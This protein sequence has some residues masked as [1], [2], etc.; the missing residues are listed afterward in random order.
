M[1]ITKSTSLSFTV[2]I[3]FSLIIHAFV[4]AGVRV[5]NPAPS[6]SL[7]YISVTSIET[8]TPRRQIL[9]KMKDLPWKDLKESDTNKEKVSA[10]PIEA[11]HH[12]LQTE[13]PKT[14]IAG[15]SNF[16]HDQNYVISE[17]KQGILQQNQI[18]GPEMGKI[19]AV[20]E[21]IPVPGT[22]ENS[23]V[24]KPVTERLKFDLYWLGMYVGSATL[25]AVYDNGIM[26]ITS[27]AHSAPVLSTFYNVDDY[28]ESRVVDGASANFRIKQ[29]EGRYRSDKETIFDAKNKKITFFNYLKDKKDEHPIKS[30]VFWDVISG[31]Y[32]LR[33]QPLEVGK[34]I[35]IDV[36]DSNKFLSVE[37]N[38][39]GKERIELSDKS[40]IDT[41]IVKP[42]IKSEGLFQK[43]G[44]IL[45]WLTDDENKVPVKIETEVP[46]GKV[47][48]KLK[49][50]SAP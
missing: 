36:F 13:G 10:H 7:P 42:I 31:F 24:I 35:F 5:F 43:K 47:V 41:V 26:K 17:D 20:T 49:D 22:R 33:T 37:V 38:V 40:K 23:A 12:Y 11:G 6:F 32:Y 39:L 3:L 14:P 8:E 30:Q 34:T 19:H 25:E 28:A 2:F 18:S 27:Q 46:V 4:L 16:M 50:M 21:K 15:D 44:D 29:H 45:I 9:T 1:K 48:A